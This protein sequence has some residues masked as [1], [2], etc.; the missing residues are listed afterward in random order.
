MINC[1]A[2]LIVPRDGQNF[3]NFWSIQI[4]HQSCLNFKPSL[5][6]DCSG[7]DHW[8]YVLQLFHPKFIYHSLPNFLHR[9]PMGH[10]LNLDD[11]RHQI[12]LTLVRLDPISAYFDCGR[13][14]DDHNH[15]LEALF[16][17]FEY[18]HPPHPNRRAQ[19]ELIRSHCATPTHHHSDS[20]RP[21]AFLP[22]QVAL[23]TQSRCYSIYRTPQLIFRSVGS[24]FVIKDF[25][26][27]CDC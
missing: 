14:F 21:I 25:T 13:E 7:S 12:Q 17:Q 11:F 8:I 22:L 3:I 27:D 18:V 6:R 26:G 10:L 2:S 9:W 23:N 20:N 15:S 5:P 1:P 19:W 16:F 4:I 24:D